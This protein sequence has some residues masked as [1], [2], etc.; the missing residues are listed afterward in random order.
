MI[1]DIAIFAIYVVLV[2]LVGLHFYRKNK[3]SD[4]YYVAGR[5]IS[6]WHIGLSVVATD[7][8][9]GFSI[10]LGGLG[11]TMGLSGSWLLFT[12]LIGAWMAAVL[13]IPKVYALPGIKRLTTLPQIFEFFYGKQVAILA[14]LITTIG[15][16]GF[17]SSQIIAGAK[18]A[19]GTF[20]DFSF[21]HAVLVMGI[22]A[23][24][25]TIL[26]GLKAVIY[27]DTFQWIILMAGLLFAGIPF[28]YNA[29]GGWDAINMTLD[30]DF[31]TLSNL[32][33]KDLINW[34]V[35]I[36]PIWFV[37]MTLY[38]RIFASRG[39]KQAKKAWFIAGL[40][41]WPMMAF[42][43]VILGLFS[44]VAYEQGIFEVVGFAAFTAM[45][46]EL[47]LPLL[48]RTVLPHGLMG[49]V[50][51]AYF[52][53][54]MSTA[55][56]CLMACSGSFITDILRF[57]DEGSTAMDKKSLKASQA[58][59]LTL[60]IIALVIALFLENVLEAMLFSYAFMVS[61]LFVPIVGAFYWKK[62]SKIGAFAAMITG[63][64]VTTCLTLLNIKWFG[65]DP[66]LYGII[67]ALIVFI[68]FGL[69]KNVKNGYSN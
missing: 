43:G 59:T 45:D 60:G 8:G 44:R 51:A 16:L 31:L 64:L 21:T 50:L 18:L 26:G 24:G 4:D 47:G 2:F 27:T 65:L 57:K 22:V 25:Y 41:E 46:P 34:S 10:G 39:E 23:I 37:G 63:G 40:F 17:T 20:V 28:A 42:L 66:N 62:A 58:A 56:S 14:G 52:S 32:T 9:G 36:I 68:S 67:C 5:N 6:S 15:Y 35:T 1:F 29:I 12:G 54:V 13:L 38:Q 61:G 33:W 69:I 49:L 30:D 19:S 48:L 3:T 11:F 55:D 53:A 7:V